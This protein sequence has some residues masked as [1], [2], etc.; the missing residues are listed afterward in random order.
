[1]FLYL[2]AG[3]HAL[4]GQLTCW[5]GMKPTSP[6]TV[7]SSQTADGGDLLIA[8]PPLARTLPFT[9]GWDRFISLAMLALAFLMASTVA[10]A[11]VLSA[12]PWHHARHCGP[13]ALT[14]AEVCRLCN[15][16]TLTPLGSR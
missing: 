11:P 15:G 5:T 8:A 4:S 14:A 1:M 10:A 16:L 7:R 13:I 2:H 3:P 6:C 9:S 12:D